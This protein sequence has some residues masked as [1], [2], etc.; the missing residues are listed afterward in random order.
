[1][2]ELS[3]IGATGAVGRRMLS[4]LEFYGI[5]CAPR[6][7]ASAK[8]AGQTLSFRN[9]PI[10][11]QA[12]ESAEDFPENSVI[13]MSAGGAFSKQHSPQLA[14]AG[15]IVIDNSSAWRMDQSVPLVVPE[16]NPEVLRNFESGIIANPNCSTIQMVVALKPLA[17]AFGL[18]SVN[19]STY[20]S[21]SGS[22]QGGVEE[23][24]TQVQSFQKDEALRVSKYVRPIFDNLIPAIDVIGAAGHCYE[25]EKMVRETRRI[26]AMPELLVT[27]TTVRVPVQ[28]CHSESINVQLLEP[29]SR[30][31]VLETLRKAPGIHLQEGD[32]Y[33]SLSYPNDVV[34]KREVWVSRV[35]LPLGLQRSH[36]VQFWNVAD[37]LYK[38]AASNAVQILRLLH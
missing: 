35:R 8:S 11:V 31:D 22:G 29:V 26:L 5:D 33:A 21:V 37:N 9:R 36:V 16:V 14:K 17:D 1:M 15:R 6:L 2:R 13:L 7:Y 34:G 18:E 3:I 20:Q 23:L 12:F 27:A 32:D 28:H 25:E 19:V 38:G 30:E 10:S 4:E 24:R